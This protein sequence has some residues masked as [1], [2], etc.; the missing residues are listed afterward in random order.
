LVSHAIQYSNPGAEA[1]IILDRWQLG[2]QDWDYPFI[3]RAIACAYNG[4]IAM[5]AS[6]LKANSALAVFL[7]FN[8]R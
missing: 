8:Y 7:P 5:A 2:V 4:S 6:Q 1:R 3:V